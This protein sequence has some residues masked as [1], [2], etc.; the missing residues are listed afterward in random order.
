MSDKPPPIRD[1]F[2]GRVRD[3]HARRCDWAGCEE[4][5][6]FKAPRRDGSGHGADRYIW[7]C[8]EH[9]RAFNAAY[10]YFAGMSPDE[11]AAAQR[12]GHPSWERDT[13]PFAGQRDPAAWEL[14]DRM[15]ILKGQP[16]L[17]AHFSQPV[18]GSANGHVLS[19]KDRAALATLG[20]THEAGAEAIRRAYKSMVRRYH[21][22]MNGGDRSHEA[23]L[24]KVID[25]YTHLSKSAAFS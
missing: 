8:L 3:G 25:A 1:R 7:F 5:G 10:D 20:L 2:H 12:P 9:V 6:E 19:A 22:D 24:R 15:E 16:G 21:P 4:A 17:G 23:Q 18:Q 14:A 11:I 13:W